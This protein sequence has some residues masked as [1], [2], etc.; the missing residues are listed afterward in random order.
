MREFV[1]NFLEALSPL[2]PL[3]LFFFKKSSVRKLKEIMPFYYYTG[4]S[5]IINIAITILAYLDKPNNYLYNLRL[6]ILGFLLLWF[7]WQILRLKKSKQLMLLVTVLAYSVIAF[8]F[9]IIDNLFFFSS[10]SN[11]ALC[12]LVIFF[13]FIFFYEKIQ[14]IDEE[15][16]FSTSIFWIVFALFFYYFASFFIIITFKVITT[17][18]IR[19]LTLAEKKM[20]SS[21]W[22]THNILYFISNCIASMGLLWKKYPTKQG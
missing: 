21:L 20:Y 18:D 10:I 22:A 1:N 15:G 7:F 3:I 16:I 6:V 14:T 13:C 5:F 4:I 19:N 12:L 8:N 2:I 11:G 9:L 17:S